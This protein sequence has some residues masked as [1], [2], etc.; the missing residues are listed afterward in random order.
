MKTSLKVH[1][2]NLFFLLIILLLLL[3]IK[4]AVLKMW[5][6]DDA[7]IVAFCYLQIKLQQKIVKIKID[8]IKFLQDNFHFGV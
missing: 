1:N 2:I 6:H 8:I 5:Q 4:M 3:K 7:K